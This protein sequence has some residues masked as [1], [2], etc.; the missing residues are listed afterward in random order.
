MRL[1]KTIIDAA[2]Y[3]GEC[4]VGSDGQKKWQRCTFWDDGVKGLGLRITPTGVKTFVLSYRCN[5]RKRLMKLGRYGELTLAEARQRAQR[6]LLQALDGEDPMKVREVKRQG[7]TVR[8]LA[9]RYLQEHA[10]P[11]KKPY[12]VRQDRSALR[13]HVL[14]ALGGMLITEVDRG[15]ISRLHHRLRDIPVQANRVVALLSKMFSL[16][17]AWGVRPENSNPTKHVQ[18][19]KETRRQRFLSNAELTRLGQVLKALEEAH[20]E[21]PAAIAAIRLLMLTGCRQGEILSM[22]WEDVDFDRGLIFFPDSK[23]GPKAIPL[24][25]AVRTILDDLPRFQDNPFVLTGRREGSH[26]VGLNHIWLRIRERVGIPDVRLH[27]LRHSFASLGAS[28]GMGL[29]IL[30]KLLGH[31]SSATTARYAH[32]ADDPVRAAADELAKRIEAALNG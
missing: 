25:D 9:E 17:E 23:T 11:K 18:H 12:S 15:D 5:G 2:R 14:P 26:L 22:R 20:E 31:R 29:P 10:V 28:G 24:S 8:D 4:H 1:T 21:P 6:A 32:L 16:A 27:D 19:Y 30:G 13:N 7:D 3:E